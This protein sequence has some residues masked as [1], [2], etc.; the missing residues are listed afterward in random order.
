MLIKCK[1]CSVGFYKTEVDE[2]NFFCDSCLKSNFAVN[3]STETINHNSVIIQLQNKIEKQEKMIT[4]LLEKQKTLSQSFISHKSQK[5]NQVTDVEEVYE[6]ELR[7]DLKFKPDA[8]VSL[9]VIVV[10]FVV[11]FLS[12]TS[13]FKDELIFLYNF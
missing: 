1:A 2:N 13:F 11:V 3:Q 8:S 10:Y 4:L 6:Q 5:R 9:Q 7:Q 12:L